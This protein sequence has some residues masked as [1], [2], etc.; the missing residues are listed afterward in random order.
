MVSKT[1]LSILAK[2]RPAKKIAVN[3][4]LLGF[5]MMYIL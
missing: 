5:G 2:I 3:P 1:G 4:H